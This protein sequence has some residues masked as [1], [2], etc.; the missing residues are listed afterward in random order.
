MCSWRN[1]LSCKMCTNWKKK[2]KKVGGCR[3]DYRGACSK[4]QSCSFIHSLTN[5]T[6]ISI[7]ALPCADSNR[8]K[9]LQLFTTA[10]EFELF[11]VWVCARANRPVCAAIWLI[12]AILLVSNSSSSSSSSSS[13]VLMCICLSWPSFHLSWFVLQSWC[14]SPEQIQVVIL[15][16]HESASLLTH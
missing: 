2:K 8:P 15:L 13:F 5:A 14:A 6:F 16:T 7:C 11:P 10:L 3:V 1:Q 4:Q 9:Q 12:C